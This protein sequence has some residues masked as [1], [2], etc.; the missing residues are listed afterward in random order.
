MA[1]MP[2]SH[3]GHHDNLSQQQPNLDSAQKIGLGLFG[4]TLL[5][6]IG[7]WATSP[8]PSSSIAPI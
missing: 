5:A 6:M 2:V 3:P 8:D 1:T 7:G 4:A